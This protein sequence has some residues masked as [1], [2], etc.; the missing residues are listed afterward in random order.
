DDVVLD[1]LAKFTAI[2]NPNA[3]YN[4]LQEE[5]NYDLEEVLAKK[6]FFD[7]E[8]IINIRKVFAELEK[9]YDGHIV[10][11]KVPKRQYINELIRVIK[12]KTPI[13]KLMLIGVLVLALN[14]A[15][16]KQSA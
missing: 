4:L 14:K 8:S 6:Q 12:D 5:S 11:G 9:N 13:N 10:S 7:E 2:K 15:N 16:K 3:D 1:I